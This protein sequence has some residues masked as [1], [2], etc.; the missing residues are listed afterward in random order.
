MYISRRQTKEIRRSSRRGAAAVEFAL[1]API[2]FMLLFAAL[3]FGRMNMIR[4]TVNNAAY[5]AARSCIV[6]GATNAEGVSAANAIL[7]SIGVIN[8]TVQVQPATITDTTPSVT[9]TITVPYNS[10]MWVTPLYSKDGSATA[11]CTLTRDWVISTR[12]S[13]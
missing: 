5:E 4:E 3:E 7:Q 10:N 11:T 8:S 13:R 9:A 1:T 6:P 12:S 2:L